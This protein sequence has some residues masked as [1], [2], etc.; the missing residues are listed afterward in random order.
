M[1]PRKLSLR[2]LRANCPKNV[3]ILPTASPRAVEQRY[4]K[5]FRAAKRSLQ[6]GQARCFPHKMPR[7]RAAQQSASVLANIPPHPAIMLAQAILNELDRE[8]RQRVIGK[9][10]QRCAI[11]E[12]RQAYEIAKTS[13]MNTG[14]QWDLM[15]ALEAAREEDRP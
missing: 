9:L 14:Q 10:A 13:T 1:S 5:A 11:P 12:G 7:L 2:E 15:V 6:E 3:V 8:T 4:S